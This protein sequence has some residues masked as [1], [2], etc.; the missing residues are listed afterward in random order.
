M[1]RSPRL[2]SVDAPAGAAPRP[3]PG[4]AVVVLAALAVLVTAADTYVVVLA[5]PDIL[6]GVGVG[7]GELQ[8][9]TPIV[10]GFLLGYTATLPLL[11]RLADLRG[12]VPVLVGCLLL[13]AFGSLLTATAEA[14]GPAVAGRGLQG[15]GAG[16]LVPATLALV[17]DRWPPERRALPLGVVGAVQE[18]GAV[19][20]PLAG[21][22]VLAVADWRAIFWLNLLLGLGLGAGVLIPARGRR[23]DPLGLAL[24][25]LAAL[26]LGLQLAAP[27]ALAEDVTI[28]LLYV[29]VVESLAWSTPLVLAAA[30]AGVGLVLRSLAAPDGAVL[31]LRGARRLAGEVDGLGSALAVVALGSLV[32]AFAAADP[33]TQI[34]AYGPVLLPLA[35][36]AGI[37]FVLHERRAADPVLPVRAL[38]PVGAWGALLVN[39]LVG[40]ALVAALVDVPLFARST[41]TPGDQ[42]G[43]ALVL[44]RLLIAV[45]VGAVAGGWLCRVVAPRLVAA[46]GMALTAGAF[47]FM[48]GWDER[49]LDGAWSTV[50]LL[51]AGLGFG[52]AIAP[53][54]TVLLG[55]TGA[56][57]H[58]SAGALAV[59]ARSV[60]MLAGLSLLTAVALRRFTAEVDAIGTPFELCPQTPADCPAYDTA[61]GAA[62]LT[63]LH[64]VFAGAAIAAG[65]AAI[66]AVVLLRV[67]RP[68]TVR[69]SGRA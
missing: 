35:A 59:V 42:L 63:Q 21:A 11:G 32:W 60:G 41:T 27:A 10:G 57:V 61:T 69:G 46:A 52:L 40:V 53:V 29:P 22:A 49:S 18:A 28:G 2:P 15:I 14:L 4:L 64:T 23:P 65:L 25:V 16:G 31:P 24:A 9:A 7:L 44:L 48:T 54:N 55:V 20:G 12:R 47:V 30:L 8:R 13:F 51:A 5:L 68:A 66:A 34:V 36:A 62:V 37:A 38:R 43:A 50:V 17:A 67:D 19:L 39:L 45:P 26:A 3:V 58:G 1:S 33:A 56:D 6:T